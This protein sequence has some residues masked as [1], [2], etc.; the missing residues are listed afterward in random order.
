MDPSQLLRS[1]KALQ[2]ATLPQPLLV[3]SQTNTHHT[4]TNSGS[5]LPITHSAALKAVSKFCLRL[6]GLRAL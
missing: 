3:E 1:G 2:L 6:L 5:V 4:H